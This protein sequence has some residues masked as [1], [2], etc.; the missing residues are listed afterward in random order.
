VENLLSHLLQHNQQQGSSSILSL[1]CALDE[2]A[3]HDGSTSALTLHSPVDPRQVHQTRP[4]ALYGSQQ[5]RK[6]SHMPAVFLLEVG[7]MG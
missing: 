6:M 1:T 3:R 4:S 5:G 7:V 2:A